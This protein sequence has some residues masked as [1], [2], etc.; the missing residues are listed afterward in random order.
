MLA[1]AVLPFV[2]HFPSSLSCFRDAGG[3]RSTSHSHR[4][5]R[6]VACV[7][8]RRSSDGGAAL[9]YD[10]TLDPIIRSDVYMYRC[11]FNS[12]SPQ[13]LFSYLCSLLGGIGLR[14]LL[15]RGWC[16][17]IQ[18]HMCIFLYSKLIGWVKSEEFGSLNCPFSCSNVW[19]NRCT[20]QFNY[21]R[22]L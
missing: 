8:D 2:F 7:A 15:N 4:S 1:Q 10:D 22:L 3:D 12:V 20:S 19:L 21:L 16:E 6:C 5:G 14:W 18:L 11:S 17:V 13:I 9:S